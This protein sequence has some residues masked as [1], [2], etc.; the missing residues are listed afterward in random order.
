M[1]KGES[2]LLLG[3]AG[4][5]GRQVAREITK[6]LQPRRIIIVSLYE[7]EVQET[8]KELTTLFPNSP[9][10][11]EGAWG[12]IFLRSDF[13]EVSRSRLMTE[14]QQRE[15]LYQD[16]FGN[17]DT[18]SQKS[19]LAELIL[20]YKPD[21]IIDSINTATAISYQDSYTATQIAKNKIQG[22]MDAI[23]TNTIDIE[24]VHEAD[25]TF[26]VLVLSQALPQLVR[27][28]QLLHKAML[29]AGTRLYLKIG[30]TGT[31]GM[32][33]NI[34]YTHSEDRPSMKLMT[35]TAVAFAQT[36]LLFLMAR[37]PGGPIVKEIKPGA[38]IGYADVLLRDVKEKGQ[39]VYLYESHTQKLNGYLIL[40]EDTTQYKC[41]ETLK[42][43]VVDT[44][45]NGLFTKGEFEAITSLR[46]MEFITPEEIARK[47]MLEVKGANTG[48]DVIAEIDGA[49]M[50]PTYRAGYL[51]QQV[52]E[53]MKHL[54][55]TSRSHSVALGMLGPPEIGKL[56]WEA[57]LLR[58]N[59]GSLDAVLNQSPEIIAEVLHRQIRDNDYLR[60][61]VSSVGIPIL[62]PD[63]QELYRGPFIRIPEVAGENCVA[64]SPENIEL[65][66]HKGW[67]DLRPANIAAWQARFK[68]MSS[69]RQ[70]IRGRGSAAI[71]RQSYLFDD[72]RIGE[73]VGWIFNNEV[74]GFRIK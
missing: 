68:H 33:L 8:L 44:G 73:I 19:F 55:K 34:P 54:E 22:L 10:Q 25:Q 57:E 67:V 30:T 63:A 71:T 59:Y 60:Q 24:A 51:R 23:N 29:E 28:T 69:E 62:S 36:G 15:K 46:Q 40:R 5:V 48:F 3:G 32:G 38:M 70:R 35:K 58:L 17:L 26:D 74:D 18:A 31:G 52:L 49:V 56:L 72:I 43:P 2:F 37:T 16:L 14:S 64:L 66:A 53:D 7:P 42:L 20:R 9:V 39:P 6:Y 13:A 4:L 47:V 61:L 45:E 11:W 50:N 1:S 41:L 27:H 21:V 65:W 12:D